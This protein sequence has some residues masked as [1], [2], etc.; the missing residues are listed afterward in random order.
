MV[1][2]LVCKTAGACSYALIVIRPIGKK[3]ALKNVVY[4]PDLIIVELDIA[5]TFFSSYSYYRRWTSTTPSPFGQVAR[6]TLFVV[7]KIVVV[8]TLALT[9]FV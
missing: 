8:T 9:T 1:T 6:Q 3:K 7:A 4:A 5:F 2:Q